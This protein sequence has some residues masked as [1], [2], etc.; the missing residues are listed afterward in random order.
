ML[1]S[2]LYTD[3]QVSVDVTLSYTRVIHG[4]TGIRR[5]YTQSYTRI[6]R[7]QPMLH[8]ELYMDLLVSADVTLELYTDLQVSADV[9]L[10][11]YTDFTGIRPMLRRESYTDFT[12]SARCYTFELYTDLQVSADVTLRVIHGFTAVTF[13]KSF[14]FK[15]IR[16]LVSDTWIPVLVTSAT[17]KQV[18]RPLPRV[19]GIRSITQILE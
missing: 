14:V 15:V 4:F 16:S 5:C 2:E 12:V 18:D 7:Y 6:Y 9:T 3:L 13:R 8:S 17:I 11:L 1:H 10:E 19:V